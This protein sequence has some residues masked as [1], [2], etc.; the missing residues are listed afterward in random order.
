[1]SRHFSKKDTQG[2]Y[3]NG[4]Q[5]NE[6]VLNITN[7]QGHASQNNNEISVTSHLLEWLLSKIKH[8]WTN[9]IGGRMDCGRWGVSRA[10]ENDGEK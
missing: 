7:H 1:M 10:E 8:P 4:Q 9:T 6:R 5:I 3:T 2:R